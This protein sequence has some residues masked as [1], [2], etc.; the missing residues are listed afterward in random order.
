M[1]RTLAFLKAVALTSLRR[2]VKRERVLI[3]G[4]LFDRFLL[5]RCASKTAVL[6]GLLMLSFLSGCG[7][8][9]LV[10]SDFLVLTGKVVS[11]QQP[12][13]GAAVQL[14][15]LT[16][17][18]SSEGTTV[19]M[20]MPVETDE[21][22]RFS[23]N[24]IS[25]CPSADE[26]IYVLSK[27]GILQGQNASSEYIRLL[28]TVGRCGDMSNNEPLTVNEVTTVGSLWPLEAF[29]PESGDLSGLKMRPSD[30]ATTLDTTAKLVNVQTG[31]APGQALLTD[32]VAPSQ[33][34]YSLANALATCIE[35]P[36][37]D[38]EGSCSDML[39]TASARLGQP[40]T[41]LIS[42]ATAIA[43][44]PET[45][46]EVVFSASLAKQKYGPAL[47]SAP[48]DWTLSIAS[49]PA[50]PVLSPQAGT[51]ARGSIVTLTAT[52]SSVL[53]YTTD[54]SPV[55]ADSPLYSSPLTLSRNT[56]VQAVAIK[57]GADSI[58]STAAYQ[59]TPVTIRITTG[60]VQLSAG[61]SQQFSAEVAGASDTSVLWSL[62]PAIGTISSSGLYTAPTDL[63]GSKLVLITATSV[64]D[65]TK[66]A[67]IWITLTP[68][69]LAAPSITPA[70][71]TYDYGQPI[72]LASLPG[73]T[74][75]YTTDGSTPTLASRLYTGPLT[76]TTG[77]RL[78]AVTIF[79]GNTSTVAAASYLVNPL[80]VAIASGSTVITAGGT[81]QF[82]SRVTGAVNK[83]VTWS[84]S[85]AIGGI[86]ATGLYTAPRTMESTKTLVITATSAADGT[87]FAS[88]PVVVQP[89]PPSAP[90]ITPASST[91][92]RGQMVTLTGAAGTV[93]RFTVDGSTP[94]LASPVYSGPFPLT[95]ATRL[96][97]IATT[98]ASGISS[99]VSNATYQVNTVAITVHPGTAQLDPGDSLQLSAKVAGAVNNA[100][101]WSLSPAVGTLSST[102]FYTSPSMLAAGQTLAVTATS[103]ADPSK[104]STVRLS[105]LPLRPA[106][107]A[108]SPIAGNYNY[109]QMI[110]LTGAAG[111]AIHYTLDGTLP[112][113]LSPVYVS[114]FPLAAVAEVRAVAIAGLTS[115][116]SSSG[117]T[118]RPVSVTV[119]PGSAQLGPGASQQLSASVG[120]AVNT[121]VVW[122]MTPSAG[123]LSDAGLYTAPQDVTST[124]TVTITA[125]SKAD[126]QTAA[127]VQ[128]ML[129][130]AANT[131]YVDN[132]NG[133]DANSGTSAA[134]PI[135]SIAKVNSLPLKPG[136][137][138]AFMAGEEWHEMLQIQRSGTAAQPIRYVAYGTGN[139]PIVSSADYAVQWSSAGA[140]VWR[141]PSPAAP[142]LPLYV[143]L[144][145]NPK[146][147]V[148]DLAT[149]GDFTWDY[150][151]G[152]LYVYSAV[153][154]SM[155]VELPV[156]SYV[157]TSTSASHIVLQGLEFRGAL[158][159]NVF[160]ECQTTTAC[161]D[162]TFTANY[163][164]AS[165]S[166][167]IYVHLPE[168]D[169]GS[170]F[171]F[172][173]NTFA[174]SGSSGLKLT[175]GI[176]SR[177][178]DN[179]FHDLCM[180]YNPW[181]GDQENTFCDA[182]YGF[183]S[184]GRSQAGTVVR[185][186]II[187]DIGLLQS[188]ALYGGGIHADTV[189]GWDIESNHVTHT[190]A[191][192]I[193][194]EK[195]QG[196]AAR[197]NVMA[198]AGF[199]LYQSGIMVRAGDG[200]TSFDANGSSDRQTVENNTV[201]PGSYWGCN[202][203][204]TQNAGPVTMTNMIFRNN[205]CSIGTSG[206]SLYADSG[207]NNPSNQLLGNNF[208][209]AY[210]YFVAVFNQFPRT[211][212]GL[213]Q[214][215]GSNTNS[216]AGTP[217]FKDPAAGN[218]S[219]APTS[220]VR[221]VGATQ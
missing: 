122:S 182:V 54:G 198:K 2:N 44:T 146:A 9:T 132:V 15:V 155:A 124:Q 183:S 71:G 219:L 73:G 117:Y 186:N 193:N 49:R 138:V 7:N 75:R 128:M 111:T 21:N 78:Q 145:G 129:S 187:K 143:G 142:G 48:A 64:A 92:D 70:S 181:S 116:V 98:T 211:Y 19:A 126:G 161:N 165:E 69:L 86:S 159:F 33:R 207:S 190:E 104:S 199:G 191:P 34:V 208:G 77:I 206:Q 27:G 90:I 82:T 119:T 55:T 192:G 127:S 152:V 153:D 4:A 58:I 105:M 118:V 135:A 40:V 150:A 176:V 197:W 38:A 43:K 13:R 154:P 89:T 213:D 185:N 39:R 162:W 175:G 23:I 131:Y 164:Q 179:T 18:A 200:T 85:P 80:V 76:L 30:V 99:T 65:T 130:P 8:N 17:K 72:I 52:D 24:T 109:G 101:T 202:L 121:G 170:S 59:V 156:R 103:V 188:T 123:T 3:E 174:S 114:P 166:N 1:F 194:I 29:L 26:L 37:A 66:F 60:S 11:G 107:P 218:Y 63:T 204:I 147:S 108:I 81:Q 169:A 16:H 163:L 96:Q 112:T 184:N 209:E 115:D 97:A 201:A 95:S 160:V 212:A 93:V 173:N 100:V 210:H 46:A 110:T 35:Q 137:T 88:T 102:G 120:G 125:T 134:A 196:S 57:A 47:T 217:Q 10:K 20:S 133:R 68:S 14:F 51:Y 221:G 79:A 94:S 168:A 25:S 87:K 203:Q 141:R 158:R 214:I 91:Y 12:I 32:E 83:Q 36:A 84:V 136:D 172:T 167:A 178:T 215:W 74:V 171:T 140:N 31:L 5:A 56:Q 157:V 61:R 62:L 195:G 177:I 148:S 216:I 205:V 42:A 113:L 53:H 67:T 6:T 189:T 45:N 180:S 139:K 220:A 144:T 151:A 50:A 28:A 149:N 22:G 41:D 106:A